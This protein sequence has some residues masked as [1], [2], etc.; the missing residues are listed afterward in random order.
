MA[1]FVVTVEL[2]PPG[3]VEEGAMALVLACEAQAEALSPRVATNEAAGMLMLSLW[4]DGGDAVDVHGEVL[5]LFTSLW[6]AAFDQLAPPDLLIIAVRPQDGS[7]PR[8]EDDAERD[9]EP[10][11]SLEDE[12]AAEEAELDAELA[13]EA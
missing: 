12:L 13:G 5:D 8:P 7:R 10:A 3:D 1:E 6:D 9:A 2:R 11:S 4:V